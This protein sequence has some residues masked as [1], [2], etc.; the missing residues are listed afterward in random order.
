VAFVAR[1][2]AIG[3]IAAPF[4]DIN[5]AAAAFAAQASAQT[6]KADMAEQAAVAA[7]VA[8]IAARLAGAGAAIIA[9]A[10]PPRRTLETWQTQAAAFPRTTSSMVEAAAAATQDCREHNDGAKPASHHG[11]TIHLQI[12]GG[13]WTQGASGG[14]AAQSP[15]DRPYLSAIK[16]APIEKIGVIGKFCRDCRL[17]T[18]PGAGTLKTLEATGFAVTIWA[19]SGERF[20]AYLRGGVSPCSRSLNKFS[21]A[22]G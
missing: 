15:R 14:A 18:F 4:V 9:A 11:V 12:P 16:L 8:V 1:I 21:A 5:L 6:E 17:P 2:A 7:A 10:V 13:R 22:R 3:R 20:W 19:A